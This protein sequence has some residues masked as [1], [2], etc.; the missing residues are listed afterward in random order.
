MVV[1]IQSTVEIGTAEIV[2]ANSIGYETRR[3]MTYRGM[4]APRK[5]EKVCLAMKASA[6]AEVNRESK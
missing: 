4:V 3:C 2:A 5:D 1:P 6:S